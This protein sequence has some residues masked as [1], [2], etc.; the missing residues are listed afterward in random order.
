MK[1]PKEWPQTADELYGTEEDNIPEMSDER[2]LDVLN[3]FGNR[4]FDKGYMIMPDFE[5]L[6]QAI[7]IATTWHSKLQGKENA[8]R[9]D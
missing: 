1:P 2:A 8:S 9:P 4:S 7:Y 5:E 3:Y 6:M